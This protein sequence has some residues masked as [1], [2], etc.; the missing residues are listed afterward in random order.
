[1]S[2]SQLWASLEPTGPT[3][4]AGQAWH[5]SVDMTFLNVLATHVTQVPDA[6]IDPEMVPWVVGRQMQSEAAV[7]VSDA[8]K[9]FSGHALHALCPISALNWPA[10]QAVHVPRAS[11]VPVMEPE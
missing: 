5:E 10:V 6:S 7:F 2:H 9:E 1:M 3:E 8:V 4:F 11:Y